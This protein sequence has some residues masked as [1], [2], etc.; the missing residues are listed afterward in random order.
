MPSSPKRPRRKAANAKPAASM[1]ALRLR[2]LPSANTTL[3][4]YASDDLAISLRCEVERG[5]VTLCGIVGQA[6][7]HVPPLLVRLLPGSGADP[8]DE[9]LVEGGSFELG[10]VLPGE[11]Q[12]EALLPD[13]LLVIAAVTLPLAPSP[14]DPVELPPD[15]ATP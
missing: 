11:Y 8:V 12:I 14:A 1:P 3:H 7:E 15:S 4:I 10:P 5:Q 6:S 9:A 13:C 2:S